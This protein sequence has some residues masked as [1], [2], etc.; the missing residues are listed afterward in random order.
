[1]CSQF[2]IFFLFR[3]EMK[4]YRESND[5]NFVE[6]MLTGALKKWSINLLS[7]PIFCRCLVFVVGSLSGNLSSNLSGTSM[8]LSHWLSLM[9]IRLYK[10]YILSFNLKEQLSLML[11]NVYEVKQSTPALGSVFTMCVSTRQNGLVTIAYIAKPLF[12]HSPQCYHCL[13]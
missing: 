9:G 8:L 12:C 6:F 10:L 2:S 7:I 1:M 3:Y 11:Q 13:F 5:S 4:I